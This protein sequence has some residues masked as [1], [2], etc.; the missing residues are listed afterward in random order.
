M[1]KLLI[2]DMPKADRLLPYLRR[3]DDNLHYSNF[4]PLNTE[5]EERLERTLD[6]PCRTVSNATLG[7]V[8]GIQALGLPAGSRILV[9]ALTFIATGLAV[10]Q[11]GHIPVIADSGLL[12]TPE[13]AKRYEHDAVIPVCAYGMANTGWDDYSKP[14]LIDAAGA[15]GN[16]TVT[17]HTVFSLHA[18]KA[19]GAGEGG[20]IASHDDAF[21]SRAK[22]LSNFGYCG[23]NSK[24]SEYHAAV[25]LASLDLWELTKIRR[26]RISDQYAEH[27]TRLVDGVP[28]IFPIK[29][30][31]A[32]QAEQALTNA[33][34][35][36]RRFY[37][38]LLSNHPSIPT[39]FHSS[40][41][42]TDEL[43]NKLICIPFHT[44]LTEQ[45]ISKIALT[46]HDHKS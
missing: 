21:L 26:M 8:L 33:D 14:V 36:S 1:I 30:K 5:L 40:T 46:L 11:A 16:Q 35:Q 41:P 20:F 24:L 4:G 13:I 38:P 32:E 22:D 9:P 6:A 29:V 25:A 31:S 37:Y 17:R 42:I 27:F 15:F 34:I 43:A 7:L 28:T 18:T 23:T 12:L 44:R 3:I 19:L 39:E 10:I 45:D 2:P